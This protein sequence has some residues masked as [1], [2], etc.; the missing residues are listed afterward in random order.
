MKYLYII[1]ALFFAGCSGM[2]V[3]TPA[4]I[5]PDDSRQINDED[6]KKAYEA[7]PQLAKISNVSVFNA[8]NN[9]GDL[10]DVI[11][12]LPVIGKL[13]KIPSLL[14]TGEISEGRY[15]RYRETTKPI[16][17][18][19]LR[20]ISARAHSDV[21]FITRMISE[22]EVTP[23]AWII[24]SIL[25][26]TPLMV[27][28][29]DVEVKTSLSVWVFD[30]RNGFMYSSMEIKDKAQSSYHTIYGITSV[31]EN[32]QKKLENRMKDKFKAGI[33]KTLQNYIT[34]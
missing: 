33:L 4:R 8:G 6:I 30:V 22:W 31:R 16:D 21:L 5:D 23:N 9:S 13:Y 27:P 7:A 15:H 10:S 1:F 28:M 32:L 2:D 26:I 12:K 29:Y 14:A 24:S 34:K 19:R 18:K 20:L 17:I 3:Y 25:L 11:S